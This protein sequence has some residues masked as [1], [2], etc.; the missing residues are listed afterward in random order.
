VV[1]RDE[2][3]KTNNSAHI[4]IAPELNG[5]GAFLLLL[6]SVILSATRFFQHIEAM[7][8]FCGVEFGFIEEF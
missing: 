6:H 7:T 3:T 8:F 5:P 1:V 2:S 4:E